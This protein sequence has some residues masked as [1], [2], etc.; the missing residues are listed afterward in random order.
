MKCYYNLKITIN[1]FLF[2]LY[3]YVCDEFSKLNFRQ[4]LL[5]SEVSLVP[6]KMILICLF[7]AGETFIIIIRVGKVVLLNIFVETD[8]LF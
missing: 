2:Y 8:T 5:Q 7:G 3:I 1:S 4:P 6:S